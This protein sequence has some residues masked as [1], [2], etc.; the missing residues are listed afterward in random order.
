MVEDGMKTGGEPPNP[1]TASQ[2]A[3]LRV[4]PTTAPDNPGDLDATRAL[5]E[6]YS[7]QDGFH[8]PRCHAVIQD[9]TE[10]VY[11]LGDEIN[12][13]FAQLGKKEVK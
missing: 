10:A 6:F 7:D 13:A 2:S 4:R 11:H 5:I 8:C 9:I 12:Q 1:S 3:P